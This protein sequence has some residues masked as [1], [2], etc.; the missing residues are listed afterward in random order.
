MFPQ[1]APTLICNYMITILFNVNM[2]KIINEQEVCFQSWWFEV[3]SV[4]HMM[5]TLTLTEA[6]S[7]LTSKD[8]ST[9]SDR[10]VSSGMLFPLIK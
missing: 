9:S 3:Y 1:I 4:I 6:N 2:I 5:A 10:I 7:I 8:Q